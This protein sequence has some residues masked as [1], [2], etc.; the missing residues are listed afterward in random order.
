[1]G[2]AHPE[3][4]RRQLLDIAIPTAI[5]D[6]VWRG[7]TAFL[8]PAGREIPHSQVIV[9][10]RRPDGQVAYLSTIARDLSEQKRLEA[11]LVQAQKMEAIGRLAG[12][13]A[14][15]FNNLLTVISGHCDILLSEAAAPPAVREDV[16]IIRDASRSA[17]GLTRQLLAFSR[18]QVLQPRVVDLSALLANTDRMLRRVIGEDVRLELRLEPDLWRVRADSGQLEQVVMNLV[19]NSR[20]AMPRGGTLTLETA[21]VVLDESYAQRQ[22]DEVRPGGY[23]MLAVSDT[24]EGMDAETAA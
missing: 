17:A 22:R 5:R 19:V 1:M 9:A 13:V 12:G 15:D 14:H 7:E 20:D 11:Q 6:G 21:N 16:E 8:D 2:D 3:W 24:G 4:A 18:K 23:V 10:H